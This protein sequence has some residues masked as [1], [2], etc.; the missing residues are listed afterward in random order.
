M[1]TTE[2][3]LSGVRWLV[4]KAIAEHGEQN[5][6]EIARLSGTSLPSVS[7]AMKLLEAYGYIIVKKRKKRGPGKP[8]VAYALKRPVLQCTFAREGYAAKAVLAPDDLQSALLSTLFLPPRDQHAVLRA[9]LD[10]EELFSL[11]QALSFVSS[12]EK[13]VHLL[14][15]ST[16]L[17]PLRKQYANFVVQA[18]GATRK[19][20]I[21]SHS[22]PE[23]IDGL[24]RK[25]NYFQNLFKR[26]IVIF[27]PEHV[28]RRILKE[29]GKEGT[30]VAPGTEP[31][32]AE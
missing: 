1:L 25:E 21:W 20:V 31:A 29:G 4:V 7:Q 23:A 11:C 18:G 13:E 30:I 16:T 32:K 24:R 9:L 3:L 12:D 15:I 28:L 6:A 17:E 22:A 8:V 26:P 2:E 19:I 5:G 14:A 27:D 10:R